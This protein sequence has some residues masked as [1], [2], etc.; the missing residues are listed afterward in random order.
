[1]LLSLLLLVSSV[2]TVPCVSVVA[3]VPAIAGVPDGIPAF[4]GVPAIA[5]VLVISSIPADPGVSIFV[6]VFTYYLTIALWISGCYL[7]LLLYY[8][9]IEHRTG[10]FEKLPD[11]RI[12]VQSF[13]LSDYRI[14]DSQKTFGLPALMKTNIHTLK[15]LVENVD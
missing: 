8:Q 14:S 3:C 15:S 1:L 11:Y 10:K 5:G 4:A 13:N 9:N 2:T 12:W 6:G 7:F